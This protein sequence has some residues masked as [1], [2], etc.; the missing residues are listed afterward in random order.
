VAVRGHNPWR[1]YAAEIYDNPFSLRL[2]AIA[3]HKVGYSAGAERTAEILAN[4]NDL[5]LEH[6]L[7]VPAFR[8]CNDIPTCSG[9]AKAAPRTGNN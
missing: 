5:T 6:A 1:S 4:F 3:Y 7:A 9:N 8:E 2:L